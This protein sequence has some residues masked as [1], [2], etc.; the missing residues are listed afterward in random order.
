MADFTKL[1]ELVAQ[2][3]AAETAY[4]DARD[5]AAADASL[6]AAAAATATA[7]KSLEDQALA[8]ERSV[9]EALKAEI[10]NIVSGN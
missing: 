9:S 5:K 1:R 4:D 8:S 10:E 6:A 3:E 7:S 2:L